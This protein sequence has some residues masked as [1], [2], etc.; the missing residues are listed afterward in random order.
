ME[1][2]SRPRETSTPDHPA[3]GIDVTPLTSGHGIR[4]IGRYVAG[5][6]EALGRE[7]PDWCA[8]QLGVLVNG[9]A[10][11]TWPSARTWR[12]RRATI[13][14]QDIGWLA[15]AVF[16]RLAIRGSGPRLWH[17]TDPSSPF[18][19]VPARRTIATVYDL[20]PLRDAAV[21]HRMRLHRRIP[22]RIYLRSVRKSGLVIAISETT[23]MEVR[24]VLGVPAE[25]V[26]VVY[27]A[28]V[29]LMATDAPKAADKSSDPDF[30]FVG[31]PDPHKRPDLA[32][33]ALAAFRRINHAGRLT[34][35]G[36]HPDRDRARLVARARTA[37][38]A[39]A[40]VFRD[41]VSDRQLAALYTSST[42]MA[43]SRIEGF[44]LPPVEALLAG[45]RVI[46]AREP[47]YEEVL[48]DAACYA[49]EASPDAIAEA[50]LT[51]TQ[52]T[53]P[54]AA[55]RRLEARFSWRA[56]ADAL[57]AAYRTAQNLR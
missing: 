25:R 7:E 6:I 51:A 8:E 50:M 14:P 56:T 20:I 19:P 17:Q 53:P 42:L 44:G 23:A 36:F 12:A 34:F 27:P 18:S 26:R 29:P 33:D 43:L 37:A 47:I 35:V 5:L 1:T 49:A 13:R 54:I 9:A 38:V 21:M 15:S 3:I 30:L 55:R 39:D 28:V 52:T 16:D 40:V 11:L 41:L 22:Y 45:G 4:G 10:D 32:I 31:V 48:G 46:A 24:E 2:I 57:L